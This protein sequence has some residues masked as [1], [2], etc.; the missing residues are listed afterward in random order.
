MWS[1]RSRPS[2]ARLLKGSLS[3]VMQTLALGAK[4][5]LQVNVVISYVFL[6]VNKQVRVVSIIDFMMLAVLMQGV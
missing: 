2:F 5:L 3:G 4:L 1:H 6:V